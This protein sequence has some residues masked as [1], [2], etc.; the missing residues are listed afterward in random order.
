MGGAVVLTPEVK[1]AIADEVKAQ[2]A[3]EQQAAAAPHLQ[4]GGGG[5][6]KQRF[7]R[8]TTRRDACGIGSRPPYVYRE[9][10]SE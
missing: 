5:C 8:N 1:Q 2:L 6:A 9:R 4:H 10:R 7:G 3:A